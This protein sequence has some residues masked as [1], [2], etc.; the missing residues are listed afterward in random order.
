MLE[1]HRLADETG[2][3]I[4]IVLHDIDHAPAGANRIIAMRGSRSAADGAPHAI[5]Y[6]EV[7]ETIYG[8]PVPVAPADGMWFAA[9]SGT[10]DLSPIDAL[11]VGCGREHFISQAPNSSSRLMRR[12]FC[13]VAG[14]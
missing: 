7:L 8:V 3:T 14:D 9:F 13:G 2:R 5:M 11:F 6:T 4:V 1:L 12:I 10:P